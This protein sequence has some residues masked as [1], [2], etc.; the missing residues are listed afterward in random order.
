MR[1]NVCYAYKYEINATL[2]KP[3]NELN[4]KQFE[5]AID[6]YENMK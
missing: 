2:I 6:M 1:M 3:L 5:E 4:G